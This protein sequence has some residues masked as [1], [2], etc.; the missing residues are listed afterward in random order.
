MKNR[1]AA[2][3]GKGTNFKSN[4][5]LPQASFDLQSLNV[6]E[7]SGRNLRDAMDMLSCR[8]KSYSLGCLPSTEQQMGLLKACF[9]LQGSLKRLITALSSGV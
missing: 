8:I 5:I 3:C 1:K 9:D 6:A 4:L 7:K 2:Q